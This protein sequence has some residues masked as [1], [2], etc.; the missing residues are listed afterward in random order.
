MADLAAYHAFMLKGKGATTP[1]P[2]GKTLRTT[3]GPG[4]SGSVGKKNQNSNKK[5]DVVV[6]RAFQGRLQEWKDTDQQ[7]EGIIGSITNLRDR[8]SWILRQMEILRTRKPWEEYCHR[9]TYVSSVLNMDDLHL[10]LNHDV[11]QHERMLSNGRKLMSTL[12]QTQDGIG[13]RLDEWMMMNLLELSSSLSSSSNNN[14]L[15]QAIEVYGIS[16]ERLYSRQELFQS[17]LDSSCHPGLVNN[18]KFNE[19]T[20][21]TDDNDGNPRAVARRVA[22]DWK[23]GDGRLK[24]LVEEILAV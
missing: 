19:M 4:S 18:N 11:L 23:A 21:R 17:I 14:R 15:D 7:L 8:I 22:R 12:A 1:P 13:R 2:T 10:A 3:E 9:P 16:A 6:F 5:S 24:V 20:D